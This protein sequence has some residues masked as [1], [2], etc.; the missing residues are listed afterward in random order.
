MECGHGIVLHETICGGG[1]DPQQPGDGAEEP[2]AKHEDFLG[3]PCFQRALGLEEE[4][5]QARS[6]MIPR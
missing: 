2:E 4:A 1:A 3:R 5:W 6:F